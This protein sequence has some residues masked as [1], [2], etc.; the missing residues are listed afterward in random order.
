MRP[1]LLFPLCKTLLFSLFLPAAAAIYAPVL[2]I[3]IKPDPFLLQPAWLRFAGL[4][5]LLAGAGLYLRCAW[6]FTVTGR[7]TPLPTDPPKIVV[8]TGLYRFVRN[9][10][11]VAILIM[12]LGEALLFQSWAVLRFSVGTLILVHLFLLLYE[13]P[14]LR[15]RFG[16]TYR[17]Y[18]AHVPRW[19]P[20][21][22][23]YTAAGE[24]RHEN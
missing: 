21:M 7:G 15:R 12:Q 18:C 10:M 20:R 22:R 23:P 8:A 1:G 2:I 4:L 16:D 14:D 24:L 3:L 13:E 17:E 9:P 5:P 6:D 11:Y 19:L